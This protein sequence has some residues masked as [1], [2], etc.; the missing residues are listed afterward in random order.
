MCQLLELACNLCIQ[1]I[2][3]VGYPLNI[4]V[5]WVWPIQILHLFY[6]H[7]QESIEE[8]ERNEERTEFLY[9]DD[10]LLTAEWEIE[11]LQ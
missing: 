3:H 6:D 5:Q 1:G 11:V 10:R 8:I 4:W 7:V 2:S 9:V